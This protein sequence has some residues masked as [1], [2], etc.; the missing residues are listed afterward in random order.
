MR[1]ETPPTSSAPT[2]AT[3]DTSSCGTSSLAGWERFLFS[4]YMGGDLPG[5]RLGDQ[6]YLFYEQYVIKTEKTGRAVF[7][8]SGFGIC[9]GEA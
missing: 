9:E 1:R 4:D 7:L 8:A 5:E 2:T 6:A 3:S